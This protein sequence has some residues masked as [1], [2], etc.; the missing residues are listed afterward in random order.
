[1]EKT[2]FD[3]FMDHICQLP[4]KVGSISE[5]QSNFLRNFLKARP[6]I[7]TVLETGFNV[8]LSSAVMMS[9]NPKLHITS[10]DI[11]WFD[12]T[13]RAKLLLDIY[14][15]KRHTLI[16]GNSINTLPT[17]F[18]QHPTFCPDLVFIDG[19]HE[20]PIPLLDLYYILKHIKP[21]TWIII[22][23]YCKTHGMSGVIKGVNFF[24]TNKILCNI[25]YMSDDTDRGWVVAKR[26]EEP[27]PDVPMAYD[28]DEIECLLR[29]VESHYP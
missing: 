18:L 12:C 21:G 9:A 19:G 7:E 14:F 17:F 20:D 4:V 15:P 16:A 2:K 10:F 1:M 6:E 26:S 8:G 11:F 29:D 3:L 24:I 5:S 13:R 22:D 27:M 25:E 23:D 28:E